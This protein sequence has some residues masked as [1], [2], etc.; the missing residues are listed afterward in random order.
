[1]F[2]Y[3]IVNKETGKWYIGKTV[4]KNLPKYLSWKIRDAQKH[5][6]NGLSYLFRAMRKYSSNVWEIQPLWHGQTDEEICTWERHFITVFRTTH[7]YFGYNI[8]AGGEGHRG[9]LSEETK[10]KMSLARIGNPKVIVA[11]KA[12]NLH[13]VPEALKSV[14]ATTQFKLGHKPSYVPPVEHIKIFT[15][16]GE[17]TRFKP[18]QPAWNKGTAKP[19]I[20]PSQLEKE[21][22]GK[23]KMSF[24]QRRKISERLKGNR[25]GCKTAKNTIPDSLM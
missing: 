20:I 5:R 9:P 11:A 2:V 18:G 12:R 21:Y 15:K 7:P 4:T 17:A 24:E 8:C 22:V 6:E 13:D 1:M 25:N 14:R 19:H 23:R 3:K 16:A 10:R